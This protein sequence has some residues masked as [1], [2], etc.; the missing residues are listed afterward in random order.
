MYEF[1]KNKL[2]AYIGNDLYNLLHQYKCFV[3]GG[4]ITSLFCNREIN[5]VDIYFRSKEDIKRFI[6][7]EVKDTDMW[8]VAKTKKAL[9]LKNNGKLI[10]LICFDVFDT[11][12]RF[13]I[14]LISMYVWDA[15][16][17]IKKNSYCIRTS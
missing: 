9:L 7:N 13:S 2:K 8:I 17:S 3:A 5:D 1:E 10:Q 12:K 11:Q 6:L 14:H 15:S 4:T 16:I